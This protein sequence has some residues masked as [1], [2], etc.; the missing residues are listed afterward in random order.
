[1][2]DS[3]YSPT[4]SYN[5]TF[6]IPKCIFKE[7]RFPLWH[8]HIR[9]YTA[10]S[11]PPVLVCSELAKNVPEKFDTLRVNQIYLET[12]EKGRS[13]IAVMLEE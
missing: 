13:L 9:V 11:H 10:G 5:Y 1:M 8:S 3:T 2:F 6:P 12:T 7:I 4:E